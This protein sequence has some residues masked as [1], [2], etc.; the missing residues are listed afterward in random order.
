MYTLSERPAEGERLAESE[1]K[2]TN[3]EAKGYFAGIRYGIR[4]CLRVKRHRATESP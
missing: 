3:G 4:D 1:G 2:G